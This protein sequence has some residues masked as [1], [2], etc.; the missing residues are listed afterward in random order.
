MDELGT[1][2]KQLE[3][4]SNR[5][6]SN[7]Q[8]KNML[9]S[10]LKELH[11]VIGMRKVKSQ[12]VKQI[13]TFI[14]SKSQGLYKDKDRKHCLLC[15]PPGC[16]KTTLSKKYK[17][18]IDIDSLLTKNEKIFLKKHFINGNFEKHLEKE[19]NILK[20]RIKKLND[21]LILLTNHPI[22]A[23]KYQLKIIGNYKLSRNNLEKILNDRKKG[24]DFFHNDI[25]LITWY[26]NKDS[27][28]FNSFT[29]LDKIIQKYI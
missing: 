8:D 28:I 19:Y 6:A 27:I 24:N 18:L 5:L 11:D 7:F 20:N 3:D 10:S 14:S 17:K 16:G 9:I 13:K 29:D 26:L 1:F 23:E 25:T 12:I 4:K 21:E 15:G 22:Q 2:I